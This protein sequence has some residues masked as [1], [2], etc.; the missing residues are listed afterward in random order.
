MSKNRI[1]KK[2]GDIESELIEVSESQGE[3]NNGP[4]N[5]QV[6][7]SWS[8]PL[9]RENGERLDATDI[10]EYRIYG[11]DSANGLRQIAVISDRAQLSYY[12]ELLSGTHYFAIS[13]LSREAGES[14][15]SDVISITIE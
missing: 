2:D 10:Q 6:R 7:F 13:A 8:L 14:A 5:R 11:G 9:E 1:L 15:L 12:H 4:M 3:I